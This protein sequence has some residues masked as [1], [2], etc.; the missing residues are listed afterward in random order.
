MVGF[1]LY[2]FKSSNKQLLTYIPR[3]PHWV[4]NNAFICSLYA[5]VVSIGEI[6][7]I[8]TQLVKYLVVFQ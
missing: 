3:D 6:P 7:H 2:Y 1:S 8:T 5:L 4:L